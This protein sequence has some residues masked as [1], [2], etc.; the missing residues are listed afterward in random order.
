ML[1]DPDSDSELAAWV[2][3]A[4][5]RMNRALPVVDIGCGNGRFTRAF[6]AHFPAAIGTDV[7]A[8]A[9]AHAVAESEGCPRTAF[10]TL[11]ATRPEEGAEL[12]EE[13]GDAN[14]FV[15]AVLHVLDDAA[16]AGF[17][18][19]VS[20]L[21]GDRGVLILLEPA[22]EESSFGYVGAVGGDRGRATTLVRPLERAGVLHSSRFGD[23]ELERFFDVA[24]GWEHV[25]SGSVELDAVDPE[26]DT[27]SV[28]VPGYFAVVRRAR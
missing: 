27:A 18:E 8:S 2:S 24:D 4:V 7:S 16:R 28:K 9:I 12:A 6:A 1:W 26:S 20:E 22:Y 19:T 21:M 11:D 3:V 23:A 25:A 10:Q 17:V 5:H 13:I 14:V 15:R